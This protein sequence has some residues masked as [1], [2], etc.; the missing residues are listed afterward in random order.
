M[1]WYFVLTV[2]LA[3]GQIHNAPDNV[4]VEIGGFS[5]ATACEMTRREI[6]VT[7]KQGYFITVCQS[8]PGPTQPE[9]LE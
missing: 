4:I 7:N 5:S 6:T 3:P 1:I 9:S 8:K 2:F